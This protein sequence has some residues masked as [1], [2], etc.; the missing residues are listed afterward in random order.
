[1]EVTFVPRTSASAGDY[2]DDGERDGARAGKM[3]KGKEPRRKGVEVFGA[4]MER[5]GE[6]PEAQM[7]E[8]ERRGRITPNPPCTPS[9]VQANAYPS[10]RS[11]LPA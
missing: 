9:I 1:M 3:S 4:G 6:E 2:D 5:G 11:H 10:E 8:A 7:L